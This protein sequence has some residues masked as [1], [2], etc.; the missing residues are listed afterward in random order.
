M[1]GPGTFSA[2]DVLTAA[3]LNA[4][5]TWTSYSPVVAQNTAVAATV[6]YAEYCVINKMCIANVNLTC[7]TSGTS[8]QA[9]TVTLPL[10]ITS[11][12]GYKAFGS[13]FVFDSSAT[14]VILTTVAIQT[15]TDKVYFLTEAGTS[16]V[17]GLGSNPS[18][19]LANNDE[20]SF[21]IMYETA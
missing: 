9:V 19:A 2:G 7:T 10:A 13:G 12:A 17:N 21:S 6:N 5:G 15:S 16:I 1:P 11:T 20:I 3:D 4:I 18:F 14:D 8:G